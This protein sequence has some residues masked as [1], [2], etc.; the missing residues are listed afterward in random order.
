[1]LS[2]A[3]CSII[4]LTFLTIVQARPQYAPDA[5]VPAFGVCAAPG[6]TGP[7]EC[8]DGYHCVHVTSYALQCWPIG[9]PYDTAPFTIPGVTTIPGSTETEPAAPTIT[10]VSP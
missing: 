8:V 2:S 6:Y 3:F 9:A 5:K 4:A 7:S 10:A 1:M